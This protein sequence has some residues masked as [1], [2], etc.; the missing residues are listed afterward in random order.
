MSQF[1]GLDM[2]SSY[3]NIK[4]IHPVKSG[5]A[6]AK[7][8]HRVNSRRQQVPKLGVKPAETKLILAI[9]KSAQKADFLFS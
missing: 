6:G 7:Q 2:R 5:L 3:V 9:L 1:A 4:L 8:F